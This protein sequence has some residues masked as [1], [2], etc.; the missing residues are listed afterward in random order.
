VERNSGRKKQVYFY[1]GY[2]AIRRRTIR[3]DKIFP[4]LWIASIQQLFAIENI[5]AMRY[6]KNKIGR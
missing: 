5:G 6:N 3:G 1:F 4:S 2:L